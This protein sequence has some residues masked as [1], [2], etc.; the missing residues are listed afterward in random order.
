MNDISYSNLIASTDK[1]ITTQMGKFVQHHRVK[2]NRSQDDVSAAA[3]ISRSTLSLLEKDGQTSLNTFI[4]VLRVLD[5]LYVINNFEVSDEISP[6]AYAKM[7]KKSR[8]RASKK[9]HIINNTLND[10]EEL[11]W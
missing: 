3:G 9:S 7:K 1:A 6:L 8:K 11:S 4:R 10:S 5:L 2:Q